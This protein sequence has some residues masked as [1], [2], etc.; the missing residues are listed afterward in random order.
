MDD[1]KTPTFPRAGREINGGRERM[2][3]KVCVEPGLKGG[4][5][6]RDGGWGGKGLHTGLS[7]QRYGGRTEHTGL[8][9]LLPSCPPSE[10]VHAM[11][12]HLQLPL[13]PVAGSGTEGTAP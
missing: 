6:W 1:S 4:G 10:R 5:I 11:A 3:E 8:S 7:A 12:G 2:K 13:L 9:V